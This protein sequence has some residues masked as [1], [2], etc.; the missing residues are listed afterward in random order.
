VL[1]YLKAPS[2]HQ[3]TLIV[4]IFAAI[5]AVISAFVVIFNEFREMEKQIISA[6]EQ[7][8]NTQKESLI[9][10]S[11][12][13]SRAIGFLQSTQKD[14]NFIPHVRQ[15]TQSLFEDSK[16]FAFILNENGDFI[17][18]PMLRTGNSQASQEII[19]LQNELL[20]FGKKGGGVYQYLGQ[21]DVQTM[22][23]IRPIDGLNWIVGSGI[24]LDELD[25][26]VEAKREESHLRITGFILKIATLTFLLSF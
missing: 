26:V 18:K 5:F 7:Y 23:F 12:K 10:Q 15:L 13:L 19:R 20:N 22:L 14:E 1:R 6:K 3:T 11:A 25:A 24:Y 17:H 21:N 4:I 8:L 2:I 16:G 9:L